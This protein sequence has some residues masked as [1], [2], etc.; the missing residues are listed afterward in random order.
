MECLNID[1]IG[2]Y[3]DQGY[4]LN[5]VDTF[6]RWVELYA[7]P[8]ATADEACKCLL[9][10]FGRYGSPTVIR[11]DKGPH[12]ANSL[13]EKFLKATG[14]EH[15]LT[16]AYSSQENSIVE[17]NNKEIN[18]HL[19][20]LTFDTNTINDYQLLLPFVQRIMNSSY[21]ERTKLSPAD[22]LFGRS[23]DLSG[24]IFNSI[25]PQTPNTDTQSQ[26]MDKMI[27]M[28]SKLIDISKRILE[29]S[30]KEHNS[31]NSA[32]VTEFPNNSFVLVAQRTFPETRLHTLWRGPMK[33]ID[34]Q[35]GEYTL[36]DLTT[37]KE[38]QYHSTQ[39][40]KFLFDP[41]RTNPSDVSRKDYLE[42]FI[43]SILQ[44]RGDPK[45][46]S[47]IE[48]KIKWLGYDETYNSWEPWANVRELGILHEYLIVNNMRKIIPKKFK[49]NY[50]D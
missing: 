35:K 16:L 12:F 46:L 47:T 17:R 18:R 38:K 44:H 31:Q 30:D 39:I 36:L 41:M 43:E 32:S 1:F 6:T 26:S 9:I 25:R 8:H 19:R 11:S 2:P 27:T 42:F 37:N 5:I 33:V 4:V 29:D 48:F 21:N 24:G 45:R 22:L 13:I 15:N 40:K 50:Q 28:Q 49:E 7:V 14:I 20:A 10:H 23:L 3:P 34:Q